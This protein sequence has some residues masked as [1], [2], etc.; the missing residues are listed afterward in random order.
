MSKTLYYVI[1][2]LVMAGVTYLIRLL[3][4]LFFKK[5]IKSRFINSLLYYL[6]YAVLS[7]MT[8][9]FILYCS[10]SVISATVGTAIA[11]TASFFKRSLVVVALLAVAGVLLCELF[12]QYVLP[13]F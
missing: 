11:L 1:A 2:L 9:P 13:L 3:P 10:D 5:K 4:M 6:P 7:A 12:M 8:F